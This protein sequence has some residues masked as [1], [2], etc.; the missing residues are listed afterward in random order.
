MSK[1]KNQH[2]VSQFYLKNFTDSKGNIHAF[3]L[4]TCESF[5]TSTEKV[6]NQKYFYDYEPLDQFVRRE[7]VI[8][9]ALANSEAEQSIVFRKLVAGLNANDVS[10]LTKEDYWKL[11]DFIYSQDMRT[12]KSIKR[13]MQ[14]MEGDAEKTDAKFLQIYGLVH[15]EALN[16]IE[17]LTNRFW[18][19]WSNKTAHNF[20]TSDH[21]V[22]FYWHTN[23]ALEVYFPITS[24]YSVSIFTKDQF[25]S[26]AKNHQKIIELV[27][28]ENIKFYN[29]RILEQCNRQIYNAENDFQLAEKII[30]ENPTLIDPKR[31]RVAYM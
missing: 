21:P 7:Q 14:F 25:L 8:E 17:D 30:E 2:F 4:I 11:A 3:D 6:A 15:S 12:P 10:S 18:V 28:P 19:F 31:K 22:A 9:K 16:V 23:T 20:Y 29:I 1:V 26:L 5:G 24:K 13:N 27:D